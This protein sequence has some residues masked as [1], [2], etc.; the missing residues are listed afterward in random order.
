MLNRRQALKTTASAMCISVTIGCVRTGDGDGEESYVPNYRGWLDGVSNYDGTVEQRA[1]TEVPIRVGVR[2][3]TGYYKYGP[4]ALTVSPGTT[5]TW[6]G[7]GRGGGHN[8]RETEDH[9][10]SGNQVNDPGHTYQFVFDQPGIY[11]HYC[12]PLL[13]NHPTPT[14]RRP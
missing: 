7:T 1:H 3:D 4:P 8:V 13:E 2:G 14:R 5:I 9:F 11:K 12:E 10:T 6:A